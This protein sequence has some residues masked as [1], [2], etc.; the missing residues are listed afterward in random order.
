MT[1]RILVVDDLECNVKVLS[2]KLEAE[3]YQVL[4]AMSGPEAILLARSE[5][6][7]LILL[8]VMMPGMDGFET[9]R[10]LKNDPITQHIPVVMVTALDQ[11]VDRVD[12]L[13][14]GADDFLSKPIDDVALFARVRSLLRL[15]TVT[16]ELRAHLATGKVTGSVAELKAFPKNA[17]GRIL[18]V[19]ENQR[20]GQRVADKL[21]ANFAC[22]I[23]SDQRTAS[24]MA[25]QG[26]DLVLVNLETETFDGLRLCARIR[27][28][29]STRH[30]PILCMVDPQDRQRSVRA[31]DIGANDILDRPVERHELRVRVRTLLQ[32]QFYASQLRDHLDQSLEMAF[33]DELTGLFNRRHLDIQLRQLAN[34]VIGG[35]QSA[36]ILIT[37]IDHFKRV[38]DTWGHQAGDQVLQQM[39]EHLKASFRAIDIVCRYGGE[40]FVILMPGADLASAK[41]ASD[42]FR[43]RIANTQFAIGDGAELIRI[44]VSGGLSVLC[45]DKTGSQAL[46]QADAALYHAKKNGRNRMIVARVGSPASQ[47]SA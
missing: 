34:R 24:K 16:D 29:E 43:E 13:Q 14:A 47:A 18:V 17:G 35:G 5:Q 39:A 32:R 40:E 20:F 21:G 36:V 1:G 19:E 46:E 28:D 38:N 7:D 22:Q 15:N 31:L 2:V 4:R 37:D 6:P 41:L 8:D 45:A 44:T 25:G 10:Q 33:I 30:L 11:Q 12:G 3:Y 27:A 26:F 23:I 42:R 9:C